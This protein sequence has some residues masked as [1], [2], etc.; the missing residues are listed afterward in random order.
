VKRDK[1]VKLLLVEDDREI[2][3][4][5]CQVLAPT[6]EVRIVNTGKGGLEQATGGNYGIIVLDLNLP[7][8]NGLKVCQQLRSNKVE[9]P[10]LILTGQNKIMDK[11]RL[12]DAG[13]DDYLTKP[14]SLGELKARLRV[15][16]RR[17]PQAD[18]ETANLLVGDISLDRT[19]HHVERAGQ[20][21]Y[22]RR[23]EFALLECLMLH[24]GNVVSR[25][26]LGNYIWPG[27]DKPWANTIDVHIKHLR[28]KIDKP[29][30][31]PVIHTVHGLGYKLEA[32]DD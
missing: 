12:L 11:I 5:L 27:D 10:I 25:T 24:A 32:R 17:G 19:K 23:K 22:L 14:F 29:F 31:Y 2:A 18:S 3:G 6:Y 13:A 7:D 26:I 16:R 30:D 15:L 9:T 8:I 20:P 4:A 28:D 1:T 21:I